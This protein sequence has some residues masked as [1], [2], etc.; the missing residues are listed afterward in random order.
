MYKLNN[1][2]LETYGIIPGRI[3]GEHI[4]VK[5]IFD[6]PKRIGDTHYS[7]AESD[8]VEPYVDFGNIFLGGR[9]ILFAGILLGTKVEVEDKLTVFNTILK[10][11]TNIVR[12]ETPYGTVC[13]TIK[14]LTPKLYNGGATF[15][16]ECREPV[17]GAACPILGST[18]VYSS[19]AYSE[20]AIKNDCN[21][22]YDGTSVQLTSP[23]G[24]FTSIYSQLAANQLAINWV[25][26]NKQ[27]NANTNGNCVIQPPIY[28]NIK[29][30]GELQKDS[31]AEGYSGSIVSYEVPAFTYSSL[32]SQADADAKAQA[33][34]DATLTQVYANE[35]GYCSMLPSFKLINEHTYTGIGVFPPWGIWQYFEVGQAVVA[36]TEYNL[37]LFGLFFRYVSTA[38]DTP[39]DIVNYFVNAINAVTLYGWSVAF[40]Q[41]IYFP[42]KPVASL[43]GNNTLKIVVSF[44]GL[45]GGATVWIE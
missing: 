10:A 33:E 12:F 3:S 37:T 4:A 29:L 14:K 19:A 5:G 17:V 18:T 45:G 30:T 41:P 8:G 15:I 21:S 39:Q 1:I 27:I 42:L 32:I 16:L 24:K 6:L 23:A 20:S 40:Q 44:V 31:C 22:G 36:G 28:Y 43:E 11:F 35:N 34:L 26:E 13:V 7:W 2:S 38:Q 9:T 25:K